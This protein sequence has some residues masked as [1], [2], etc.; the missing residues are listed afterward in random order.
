MSKPVPTVTPAPKLPPA[1]TINTVAQGLLQD[2]KASE[3]GP[4]AP[5]SPASAPPISPFPNFEKVPLE[6]NQVALDAKGKPLIT[7]KSIKK[8]EAEAAK[9]DM[10]M[11][12]LITH[13][14]ADMQK[15]EAKKWAIVYAAQDLFNKHNLNQ[16]SQEVV[17]IPPPPY[18]VAHPK[19]ED[20]A[21]K[22]VVQKAVQLDKTLHGAPKGNPKLT[23]NNA[24]M[25][26]HTA[27]QGDAELL[28]KYALSMANAEKDDAKK[29][30]VKKAGKQL[31]EKLYAHQGNPQT[32]DLDSLTVESPVAPKSATQ[33]AATPADDKPIQ[34][35]IIPSVIST[36]DVKQLET[37]ANEGDVAA[38]SKTVLDLSQKQETKADK[39]AVKNA[40]KELLKQ[41]YAKQRAALSARVAP[42][43]E[44]A[45]PAPADV[46][47]QPAAPATAAATPLTPAFGPADETPIQL[48]DIPSDSATGLPLISTANVKKLEK[49]ANEGTPL[50]LVSAVQALAKAQK[51]QADQ[52]AVKKAGQELLDKLYAK[53]TTT[54]VS[55]IFTPAQGV[56]SPA[57]E[58]VESKPAAAVAAAPEPLTPTPAPTDETP[59]QLDLTAPDKPK[60]YLQVTKANVKKLEKSANQGNVETLYETI[61][62]LAQEQKT[63]LKQY[64]I[65]QSGKQL[66]EKLYAKQGNPQ[67]VY[68]DQLAAASKVAPK[69]STVVVTSDGSVKPAWVQVGPQAGS[70][71]GGLFEDQDG[72]K[73]YIKCPPSLDHVNN[74]LMAFDLYQAVGLNVPETDMTVHDGKYCVTSKI[75]DG[76][77][78]GGTNPKDLKGTQE[79]FV[80]DAWLANWDSVGVGATKYDNILGLDGEAYRIDAGGALSYSGLGAPK[81]DK[82]GDQV[83]ELDALRDPKVNPVAAT[84]F[85]DMTLEQIKASAEPVLALESGEIENIVKL[86]QG[87][88]PHSQAMIDKLLARQKY[89]GEWIEKKELG[90]KLTKRAESE[91]QRQ[92]ARRAAGC[93]DGSA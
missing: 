51:T 69:S 60:T 86:H 87:T 48:A 47:S 25:L 64:H 31:L 3:S 9:G 74:E 14:L 53:Q 50:K 93:G 59:I 27:N 32:V 92:D 30:A 23:L 17:T 16:G 5:K 55:P 38:L 76:L 21:S 61:A 2:H 39:A 36:A 4:V 11:L 58:A 41:V 37:L 84:V 71:P 40:G 77:S 13:G 81:G 26:E 7:A 10:A 82:F 19:P 56:A 42:P 44:A 6:V 90:Q 57:P 24:N 62:A 15:T 68:L 33:A 8:L 83:T 73:H 75:I 80:A 52:A 72:V 45:P 12:N 54:P 43:Q 49:M 85:G 1:G 70:T 34:L 91:G 78:E 66:L 20:V 28:Q 63:E 89:I 46:A 88:G 22:P 65:L 79:G 67:T 35:D 18:A 29:L